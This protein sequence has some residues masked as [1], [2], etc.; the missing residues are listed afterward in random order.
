MK[1]WFW[2]NIGICFVLSSCGENTLTLG[3][4]KLN[5]NVLDF[6][7]T[8]SIN[9]TNVTNFNFGGEC[10]G[11]DG[12]TLSYTLESAAGGG[13]RVINQGEVD[14]A[15]G[16]W[17]VSAF[18][19]IHL[20]DGE[21]RVT[22]RL[23]EGE[24]VTKTIYKD[25]VA[26]DVTFV[27]PTEK[28]KEDS[29]TLSGVCS[30]GGVVIYDLLDGQDV[31]LISGEAPCASQGSIGSSW[32]VQVDISSLSDGD[33]AAQVKLKD[34]AENLSSVMKHSFH[35]D[36]TAP[37]LTL[38]K[39]PIN[40]HN[41]G[42][43]ILLGTC[44]EEGALVSVSLAGT[45][46]SGSATCTG[47]VWRKENINTQTIVNSGSE[48]A[49]VLEHR[50]D[51]G[52]VTRLE[53][54]V[55]RD[56]VAPSMVESLG[57]PA[58]ATYD[59]ASGG[60]LDFIVTYD[61]EV[62]VTRTPR[63]TLTVG[64]DTLYANYFSQVNSGG[65]SQLK[66]RYVVLW[67]HIDNN[68]IEIGPSLSLRG[69]S[70][71]DSNGNQAGLSLTLPV[72]TG[73]RVNGGAPSLTIVRGTAGYYKVREVITL[74]ATF[75]PSV[76]VTG[77]PKLVL[78]IG[79][80]RGEA[81][82]TGSGSSS[83]T[84]TF[85]YTVAS[86]ENDSDG[87]DV[88]GIDL[89]GGSIQNSSSVS[90]SLSFGG[91]LFLVTG[92]EV[93]TI[94]PQFDGLSDDPVGTTSKTWDWTCRDDSLPCTYRYVVNTNQTHTFSAE[95]FGS[96]T[97]VTKNAVTGT[98]YLHI[99]AKDAGGNESTIQ[100]F[101]AILDHT[102]PTLSSVTGT[103]GTYT[104]G[105]N[106]DLTATFSEPVVVS[107]SATGASPRL[108]LD[109]GGSTLYATYIGDGAAGA[110]HIFRYTV[111]A[112]ESDGDGLVVTG[113]NSNGGRIQ[114]VSGN[115]V[116]AL[117]S[118]VALSG[119]LVKGVLP[120]LT[121]L[122]HDFVETTSKTWNWGCQ[123][124]SSPCQYRY[125]VNTKVSPYS[126]IS[127]DTWGSDTTVIQSTGTG[128]H[129]LHIQA[130]DSLGNE[131][132]VHSFSAILE[133][134]A[135][136]QKGAIVVP[137]EKL[138]KL[139]ENLFFQL[140]FDEAM[141][142]V[143]STGT[144]RLVFSL[145]GV[146]KYAHYN[147][148]SG[149]DTLL[150]VLRVSEGDGDG[151]VLSGGTVLDLNGGIISG[152]DSEVALLDTQLVAL[153]IQDLSNIVVDATVPSL[154]SVTGI[155]NIYTVGEHVDLAVIFSEPVVVSNSATDASPRLQLDV[156]G[157]TL[158]A[159]YTGDGALS[160]IHPFRYTVSLGENDGDGLAVK[161]VNLNGGRI[162][163]A[164]EY[165]LDTLAAPLSASE[166]WVDT[167]L[168]VLTGL[169][170]DSTVTNSK[171]WSWGCRDHSLPCTYRYVVNIN[172]TH[173]FST[174]LFGSDTT[175]TKNGAVG[176]Y[177]LHIQARDRAGNESAVQSFSVVLDNISPT[178][179]GSISVPADRAYKLGDFL[180][181]TLNFNEDVV[182]TNDSK[183]IQPELRLNLDRGGPLVAYYISGSGTSTWIFE[184]ILN[185]GMEDGDGLSGGT[186]LSLDGAILAD[187][188]GNIISNSVLTAL[189]IEDMSG[190]TID[191]I[192]PEWSSLTSVGNTYAAGANV[193]LK[194]T[195][196]EPVVVSSSATS[197]FPRL[198]LDVG[199]S[200]LYAEYLGTGVS[201]STHL[202]NYTVSSEEND[203]N[204][205]VVTGLDLSG[206]GI[207]DGNGNGV[208]ILIFPLTLSEVL[209]DTTPAVL[210]GLSNDSEVKTSKI[211]SWDC[212]DDSLPCTYRY[213]VNTNQA[214]TFNAGTFGSDT[215]MT[216]NAV[217]GTYYLHIQA[218]DRVGNES[219]VQSFS[220]VLD[221]TPPQVTIS[222][223]NDGI[224]IEG[225]HLDFIFTYDEETIY[226]V[227]GE[228]IIDYLPLMIGTHE[229][230]A[231]GV[232]V[233]HRTRKL[234]FR[235]VVQEGETDSDGITWDG[236]IR[237]N[238]VI[239]IS[240][241]LGNQA[242]YT[243]LTVPSLAGVKVNGQSFRIAP[244]RSGGWLV[245]G[246]TYEFKVT[247]TE[248]VQVTG[249]PH[250]IVDV[251][252]VLVH[253][254]FSGTASTLA[255]SHNFT[256]T[257]AA[258]HNDFDGI[259]IVGVGSESGDSIANGSGNVVGFSISP[260]GAPIHLSNFK[261]D[262]TV[263]ATPTLSFV[264]PSPN[265]DATPDLSVGPVE[266]AGK[267]ESVEIYK[268]NDCSG[269]I[270]KRQDVTANPQVVTL[271][272]LGEIGD[273][274][275]S[276]KVVD[277]ANHSSACS[278]PIA[279]VLTNANSVQLGG[280]STC[281]MSN[282]RIKCW[283]KN[284][285]G[286]LGQ[287]HSNNLG[288]GANEVGDNLSVVNLGTG[289]DNLVHSMEVGSNRV[290]VLLRNN[291]V[292]CWGR[293]N[294]G[295][296]GLGHS[297]TIGDGANE[298]G[299]NLSA[300]NLG[301]NLT[302]K[303]IAVGQ[304]HNC[305]ILNNDSVKCWG[306]NYY[307]RL[308]Q[309]HRNNLGDGAN[310]MGDSLSAVNLG[311]NLTAKQIA[312]GDNHTCVILNNDNV[313]CWGHNWHG[314]L[315]QGHSNTIGDGANEMGDNLSVVNL[316]TNLTAKQI[317]TGGNHTCV[318][319][320]N[321]NVKCWGGNGSGA[322]GLESAILKTGDDA[323][324]MGD[325]LSVVQLGTY[326]TAKQITAGYKHNCVILNNDNIKCWGGNGNGQLGLG[327]TNHRGD[328]PSEMWNFL[329][330]VNLG[331]DLTAK[332][333]TAGSS[334]TC[335]VLS[336]NNVR[337]WGRNN[338]GQLGQGNR[339]TI[340][341]NEAVASIPEIIFGNAF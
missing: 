140:S 80:A 26:P 192:I 216:K 271:P 256:Y 66:F 293:N 295:Q 144:P 170:N 96:N 204:G 14:C 165:D 269:T 238:G 289:H 17:E 70:I 195:F 243:G 219:E 5:A 334:N 127:T 281:M 182:I 133:S 213:V 340:G 118:S 290:C 12:L 321:D 320:N 285:Y 312:A 196:S 126:F 64:S 292:K 105:E 18:N 92:V 11:Y 19:G 171:R 110:T 103:G 44:E 20:S 236:T 336:N 116:S 300:V 167:A 100:S 164:R 53:E 318:I 174:E 76:V 199:G 221:N 217:T 220:A 327:D 73:I 247:F 9:L 125:K 114:D 337:C 45:A 56:I 233:E 69:G 306:N 299:D 259:T 59:N 34:Q 314:Q 325:N 95:T 46:L 115:E 52:N 121:G 54:S 317:T 107:S 231:R 286:Q 32:S 154:I 40:S 159:T 211:W 28:L 291:N 60:I 129:Y 29:V 68:G 188:A 145:G 135:S 47:S 113:I 331:A 275:F 173:T 261:V 166:I 74:T 215:T 276:V 152:V 278:S 153:R 205:I 91:R 61:D 250:L 288:D 93:D 117:A 284:N 88:A 1:K 168:P 79:G 71:K 309:G 338:Y 99:Q 311:T 178:Q 241:R 148:G 83:A 169:G 146:K 226:T 272:D 102:V 230:K 190:I 294:H 49:V 307:G 198:Q 123:S 85:T 6:S 189:R 280:G 181:F 329:P 248:E 185:E 254:E 24:R 111:S 252:G 237:S 134:D 172:Q 265:G 310:E 339:N 22:V 38:E 282:G 224:Y 63:L 23:P 255:S 197:D 58:D 139:G 7:K 150:F 273:Y 316:G 305:V 138:Y 240:D 72:L 109:G 147:S 214:H 78:D 163:D 37:L 186:V 239:T 208:K 3:K 122:G 324:E 298:M 260:F 277:L 156:G 244:V 258:A 84:H 194:A 21:Y 251:G 322:L 82:Y 120:V 101:S 35:R 151:G 223:P 227:E 266:G 130:R 335:V 4:S 161:G 187:R 263:P 232:D 283:G 43:Y 141:T 104:V 245:T 228:N 55:V 193:K 30:E 13:A 36:T 31:S 302:A 326:L 210:T 16:T 51:L 270:F 341:D 39:S 191:A 235:Y 332:Q 323:N 124:S 15:D 249:S 98:Y 176:T 132:V 315:G 183:E 157:T 67:G 94:L 62:T 222:V 149:T 206:G 200:T 25:V 87:I 180:T 27:A 297:N 304:D 333:I 264:S 106:V 308:G 268:S 274:I 89:N 2:L 75:N 8:S 330:I 136:V 203:G 301:T 128:V 119:I 218:R 202:F 177:Y 313:K 253:A 319:L 175:V 137:P 143:I 160:R 57:V 108:E 142:V 303:Q 201:S 279:Y 77:N 262:N 225:N 41:Q 162:R 33:I 207:K 212:Q 229:R 48:V 242:P 42:A 158:Y 131:S 184:G 287:G 112:G 10:A 179:E 234:V 257:V 328:R 86:G 267:G 90:A 65:R 97:M 296:L 246:N 155:G 81:I 50:D 209:V